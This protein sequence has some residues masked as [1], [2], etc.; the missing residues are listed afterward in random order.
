MKRFAVDIDEILHCAKEN[1]VIVELNAHPERLDLKDSHLLLARE[2]GLRI[3]V[4]TDSHRVQHLDLMRYGVEQ[5]RRAWLGPGDI[6]NCLP[7][8]EFLQL[9]GHSGPG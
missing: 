9:I 1:N 6:V 7:L 8:D 2:L 5:A 3:A 4:S